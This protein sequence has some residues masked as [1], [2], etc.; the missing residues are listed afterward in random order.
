MK[1]GT[2]KISAN[3]MSKITESLNDQLNWLTYIESCSVGMTPDLRRALDALVQ[4]NWD[5]R[6][7]LNKSV[8]V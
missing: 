1:L 4:L 8:K 2:Y 7:D 5:I 3:Q 6:C